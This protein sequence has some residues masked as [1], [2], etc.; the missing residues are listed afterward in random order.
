MENNLNFKAPSGADVTMSF[1]PAG[2]LLVSVQSDD[3]P[4]TI[5]VQSPTKKTTT[6]WIGG[7]EKRG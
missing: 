4:L 3:T 7:R 5:T 1:D 2:N 6:E